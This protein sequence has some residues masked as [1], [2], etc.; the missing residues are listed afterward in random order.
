MAAVRLENPIKFW[1]KD[2]EHTC[3]I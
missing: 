1:T 3:R 2:Y